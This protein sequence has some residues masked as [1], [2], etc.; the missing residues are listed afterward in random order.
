MHQ[1]HA[2]H[3]KET[4]TA[5]SGYSI[6]APSPPRCAVEECMDVESTF[7]PSPLE[8]LAAGAICVASPPEEAFSWPGE[9]F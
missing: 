2:H 5:G 4:C 6:L 3:G 7:V 8:P 9:A 1:Q